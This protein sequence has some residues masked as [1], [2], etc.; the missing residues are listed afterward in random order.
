MIDGFSCILDFPKFSGGGLDFKI[1][2]IRDSNTDIDGYS[3]TF[4]YE[5]C[6]KSSWTPSKL[7]F[8]LLDLREI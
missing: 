2:N 3:K 5:I 4:N 1:N 8:R 7:N 6:P